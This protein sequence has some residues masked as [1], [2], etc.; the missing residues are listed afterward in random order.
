MIKP[1]PAIHFF[2]NVGY[3]LNTSLVNIGFRGE[4]VVEN[5]NTSASE[6]LG[7]DNLTFT[8]NYP[9]GIEDPKKEVKFGFN[10]LYYSFGVG[11]NFNKLNK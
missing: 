4:G 8:I 2:A 7:A 9:S 11:I 1:T 6:N 5:E 10:G 3:S